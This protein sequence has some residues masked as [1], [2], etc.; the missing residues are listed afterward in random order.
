[1][2]DQFE[3]SCRKGLAAYDFH[4]VDA[5]ILNKDFVTDICALETNGE[6]ADYLKVVDTYGTVRGLYKYTNQLKAVLSQPLTV[7]K[8]TF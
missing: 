7:S 2:Y 6:T 8:W 5:H 1:M 4:V 3:H